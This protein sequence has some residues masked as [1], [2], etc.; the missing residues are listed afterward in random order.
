MKQEVDTAKRTAMKILHYTTKVMGTTE[1]G[2][3]KHELASRIF[4]RH[5]GTAIFTAKK[6]KR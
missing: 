5:Y 4:R 1:P 3:I 6:S 2:T